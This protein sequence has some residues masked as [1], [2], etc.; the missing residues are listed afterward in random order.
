MQ[1]ASMQ[2]PDVLM[3]SKMFASGK[4]RITG[5]AVQRYYPQCSTCSGKQSSAVKMDK[6]MLVFHFYGIRPWYYAGLQLLFAPWLEQTSLPG[7]Q[8][9]SAA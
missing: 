4:W 8:K 2:K 6:A 5:N 9:T 3:C 7:C 1:H